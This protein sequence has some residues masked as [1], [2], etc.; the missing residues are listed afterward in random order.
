[1]APAPNSKKRKLA[2]T[3][4]APT[5]VVANPA[6]RREHDISH[7]IEFL[8]SA[9]GAKDSRPRKVKAHHFKMR[10][11]Y[12]NDTKAFVVY[13]RF[14]SL[15]QDGPPQHS[16]AQIRDLTGVKLVSCYS[17]IRDWRKKGF[18]ISNGKLGVSHRTKVTVELEQQLIN[19]KTLTEMAPHSL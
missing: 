5:E 4:L 10:T 13:L 1:M 11:T 16:M 12:S 9:R 8:E 15:T 14:G 7:L 17:I 6:K 18:V 3:T 2:D 19:T